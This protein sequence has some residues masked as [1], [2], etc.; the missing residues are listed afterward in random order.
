MFTYKAIWKEIPAEGFKIA[1]RKAGEVL[2]KF[3]FWEI[4]L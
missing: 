3:L 2:W 4:N 1:Q